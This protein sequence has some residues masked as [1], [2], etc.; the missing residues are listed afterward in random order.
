[1]AERLATGRAPW[2]R[3]AGSIAEQAQARQP[4]PSSTVINKHLSSPV[5]ALHDIEQRLQEVQE[6]HAREKQDWQQQQQHWQQ[7]QQD[8]HQQQQ[9]LE[10]QL[11]DLLQRA[12]LHEHII[13]V[14]VNDLAQLEPEPC[15]R[16]EAS[17]IAAAAVAAS[18][19]SDAYASSALLEQELQLNAALLEETKLLHQ[20]VAKADAA[21]MAAMADAED[22]GVRLRACMADSK[23]FQIECSS[24]MKRVA[25][26][27]Q[28]LKELRAA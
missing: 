3:T 23:Q 15:Q 4:S 19:S 24:L 21:T 22:K 8:W 6:E 14:S 26:R 17:S 12:D 16:A 18:A 2:S 5:L 20:R 10:T 27:D 11:Y 28:A 13:A 9:L 7:R 25:R 1:M